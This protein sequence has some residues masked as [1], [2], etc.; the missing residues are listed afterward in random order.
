MPRRLTFTQMVSI[1]NKTV[2]AVR[3]F[4]PYMDLPVRTKTNDLE[5]TNYA[6][7]RTN[8]SYVGRCIDKPP[9]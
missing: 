3:A 9:C 7:N 2:R 1:K 4:R 8:V 5:L 6:G